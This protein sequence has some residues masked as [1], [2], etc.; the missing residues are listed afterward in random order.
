MH[1]LSDILPED[2]D[3]PLCVDPKVNWTVRAGCVMGWVL[4][5]VRVCSVSCGVKY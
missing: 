2:L 4:E 5:N 1:F 3:Y